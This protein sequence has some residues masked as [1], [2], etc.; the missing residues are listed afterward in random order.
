MSSPADE[1]G[2]RDGPCAPHRGPDHP[3]RRID[4]AQQRQSRRPPRRNPRHHRPERRGQ[5]HVLQLRHRRA[6]A[7]LGPHPAQRQR[8]H[9]P[10]A[11]PDLAV[12]HRALLPDHQHPAE[13]HHAGKRPH[14]RAIA[15]ARLEH[16]P[17][18]H[19]SSATSSTR[20]RRCWP[21]SGLPA[22]PTSL[23]PTFRMASSAISRSASRLRP[24]R[25]FS[26]STSRPPA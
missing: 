9:R 20:R 23:P 13:R 1:P 6:A 22:R 25:S 8:H 3:F 19:A 4:R 10:A 2:R 7:D 26:A 24:S 5:E 11:Q 18:L 21:R 15:P 12:R 17:A 16:V 14:R